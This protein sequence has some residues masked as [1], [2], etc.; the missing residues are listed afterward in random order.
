MKC[1]IFLQNPCMTC[2]VTDLACGNCPSPGI[3]I[4]GVCRTDYYE[5]PGM[6]A[7][8]VSGVKPYT[9]RIYHRISPHTDTSITQ[10][11]FASAHCRLFSLS[12]INQTSHDFYF[13]N[14]K[15]SIIRK[16]TSALLQCVLERF[17]CICI[18]FTMC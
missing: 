4:K 18:P 16:I 11:S 14:M 7:L 10:A 1:I 5:S 17:D 2:M 3:C 6:N 13:C 9:Q 15:D 8:L 12:L